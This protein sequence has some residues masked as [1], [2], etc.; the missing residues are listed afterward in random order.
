MGLGW[1]LGGGRARQ[2]ELPGG[3]G[4]GEA[5][6]EGEEVAAGPE[7]AVHEDGGGRVLAR[8]A[9]APADLGGRKRGADF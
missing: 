2:D 8:G 7:D 3:E 9:L 5:L 6:G 4:L 1:K